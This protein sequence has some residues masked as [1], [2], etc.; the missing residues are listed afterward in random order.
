[1][2]TELVN[3]IHIDFT[4]VSSRHNN[5]ASEAFYEEHFAH[6][7]RQA[8]LCLRTMMEG[9]K[10]DSWTVKTWEHDTIMDLPKRISELKKAGVPVKSTR[11]GK[12]MRYWIDPT[13]VALIVEKA[14][15]LN[16]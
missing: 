9:R 11:D 14:N 12:M 3:Q 5:T 1:M 10:L 13:D 6:F 8:R 15:T 7:R 4:K 16:A 2:S